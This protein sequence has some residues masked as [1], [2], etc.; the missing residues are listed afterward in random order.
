MS[1]SKKEGF[2]N[3]WDATATP[4]ALCRGGVFRAALELEPG[5]EYQFRYVVNG[6]LWCN[7]WHAD[8]YVSSGFGGDNCV[9][10]VPAEAEEPVPEGEPVPAQ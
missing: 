7:D 6:G 2:F 8:A 5:Q 9:V 1:G 4:M 3:N 10:V